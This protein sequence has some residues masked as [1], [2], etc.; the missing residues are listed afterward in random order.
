MVCCSQ[1]ATAF[2]NKKVHRQQNTARCHTSTLFLSPYLP[3]SSLLAL[4]DAFPLSS[5][6]QG[7]MKQAHPGWVSKKSSDKQYHHGIDNAK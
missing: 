3:S 1:A 7:K 4:R 2:C 6:G 5:V